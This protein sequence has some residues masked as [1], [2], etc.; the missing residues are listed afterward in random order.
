MYPTERFAEC[1]MFF[2]RASVRQYDSQSVSQS[3]FPF[4]H[5]SSETAQQNFMN[6]CCYKGLTEQKRIFTG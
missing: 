1:K 6:L 4:Q 2:T 3:C 5:N